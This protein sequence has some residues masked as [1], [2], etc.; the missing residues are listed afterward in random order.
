MQ[1]F[2]DSNKENQISDISKKK[3]PGALL[4]LALILAFSPILIFEP[5]HQ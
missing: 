2:S 1:Y 5:Y 4:N 3:K